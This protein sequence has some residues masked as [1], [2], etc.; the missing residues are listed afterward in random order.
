MLHRKA[1]KVLKAVNYLCP[2]TNDYTS[3]QKC[4]GPM[5]LMVYFNNRILDLDLYN[6]LDYLASCEY[7]EK[8]FDEFSLPKYS[9]TYKGRHYKELLIH[10]I[11]EFFLK[12]IL[13]PIIISFIT[14]ILT[15]ILLP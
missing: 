2:S 10:S 1:Y 8:S 13:T 7:I 5:D 15:Y 11:K 12:S 3:K 4:T 14:T 6:T 9:P